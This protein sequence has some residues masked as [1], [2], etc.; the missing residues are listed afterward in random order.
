MDYVRNNSQQSKYYK[1]NQI[2]WQYESQSKKLKYYWDYF[3]ILKS[4]EVSK[5]LSSHK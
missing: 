3:Y 5:I 4:L 1:N 2:P